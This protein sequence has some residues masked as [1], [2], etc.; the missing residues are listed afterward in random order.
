VC[1]ARPL[2][3]LSCLLGFKLCISARALL[4]LGIVLSCYALKYGV[5]ITRRATGDSGRSVHGH[6]SETT[7]FGVQESA[8]SSR[9]CTAPRSA[10]RAQQQQQQQQQDNLA[11]LGSERTGSSKV[12]APNERSLRSP[13]RDAHRCS[14]CDTAPAAAPWPHVSKT[15]W[16]VSLR[17]WTSLRC[18]T[19]TEYY[20]AQ[21]IMAHLETVPMSNT[22]LHAQPRRPSTSSE[23]TC[24][25]KENSTL[26]LTQQ[27]E[28]KIA[29]YN[30]SRKVCKRWLFEIVCWLISAAS[31]G[32]IVG[33]FV[34]ISNT[35][36]ADQR[37]LL[38]LASILGKVAS[39]ALI[40]PTTEALG[41]LKW[42]WFHDSPKAMWD[43]EIFDKATR[44]PWGAAMLLY[45]TKG[46]FLA[47][48]GALLMVLLLA[49]DSFLQQVVDL[50]DRWASQDQDIAGDLSRTIRYE[51]ESNIVLRP[52]AE[53]AT[54]NPDL[55]PVTRKF[56]YDN[57]TEPLLFGNGT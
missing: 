55:F 20:T 14:L 30:A 24:Q 53:M 12:L 54:D 52:G 28:R 51:P 32:C 8:Y 43:F 10:L 46:R 4:N 1:S 29:Q 6:V 13:G 31:L 9:P 18:W 39:A 44:G 7:L 23:S 35:R 38:T 19:S 22:H 42:N 47:A 48:L 2:C 57:G 45:R 16:C 41:Q 21:K 40:V 15:L 50:P 36:L 3:T 27:I 17:F 11:L 26:D 25:Q 34:H 56:A 33:I 49:I 37:N 5:D